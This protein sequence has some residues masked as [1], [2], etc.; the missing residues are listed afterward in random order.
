MQ[1]PQ[2]QVEN[3]D[4]AKFCE[5]CGSGLARSCPG[6]GQEV[7]PRAKFCPECGTR[8]IGIHAIPR[9]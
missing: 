9:P 4:N 2:C 8:L 5:G 6:C 3:H 1:C 7:S